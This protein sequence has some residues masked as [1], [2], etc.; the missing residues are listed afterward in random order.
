MP[1]S[2]TSTQNQTGTTSQQTNPWAPQAGALTT[3]FSDAGNALNSAQNSGVPQP[4]QYTAGLTPEQIAT[5]NQMIGYGGSSAIPGQQSATGTNMANAGTNAATGALSSLGAFNPASTNNTA[6]NINAANQYVAGQNIPGQVAADMFGANQ[7]A[8]QVTMPGIDQNAARTGNINSSRTGIA[9]GMV[10]ESLANQA[11]G[12]GANLQAN[13]Y[14]TGLGLASNTNQSNNSAMLSALNS[15][16]GIGNTTANTGLDAQGN[17]IT[18][19]GNLFNLAGEGGAGLQS[20]NQAIDTNAQQ[21]YAGSQNNP[22]MALN[23]YYGIVGANN[24]GGTTTGT[25]SGTTTATPSMWSTIAG[26]LG[27]GGSL[28]KGAA[29]FQTTPGT[30]GGN[31]YSKMFGP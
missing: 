3:A 24:W 7:E 17:S 29:G 18:N 13:A 30:I 19:Q 21:A 6:N 8:N 10:K 27:A 5:F 22:F 16:G 31:L 14:N 28:A 4:T 1:G 25:S 2:S 20:G 12:L 23:N 26:L 15:E 9:D 11:A